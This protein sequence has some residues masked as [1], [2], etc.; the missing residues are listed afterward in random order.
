MMAVPIQFARDSQSVEAGVPVPLFATHVGGS[1]QLFRQQY[2]VSSDGQRFLM[3]TVSEEASASP[4]TVILNW[5]GKP[6]IP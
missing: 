3:N 6:Q 5:K 4:I 2:V 1:V